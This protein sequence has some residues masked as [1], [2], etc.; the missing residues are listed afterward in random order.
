MAKKVRYAKLGAL[1][2]VVASVDEAATIDTL[3][4]P[5]ARALGLGLA[6]GTRAD[7]YENAI[8]VVALIGY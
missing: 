3:L 7:T 4:D 5:A 6:Q 1:M 2:T 8:A